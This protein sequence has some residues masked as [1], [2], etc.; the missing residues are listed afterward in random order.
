[1]TALFNTYK[2]MRQ[3][4]WP[5]RPVPAVQAYRAARAALENGANNLP[6]FRY[7]DVGH[8]VEW[9]QDGFRLVA[10]MEYDPCASADDLDYIGTLKTEGEVRWDEWDRAVKVRDA[11][12]WYGRRTAIGKLW[13][14]PA[15]YLVLAPGRSY[16][17]LM[18]YY[19]TK[20]KIGKAQADLEAR[21]CVNRD[22]ERVRRWL[23]DE[24]TFVIL[25]VTVYRNGVELASESCGGIES[26]AGADYFEGL[27]L[28]LAYQALHVAK[29]T[30]DDL[31]AGYCG[32][33]D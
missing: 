11:C 28:D 21:T 19:R 24:W 13:R 20:S 15:L 33:E 9:E 31:C 16:E 7:L 25:T 32:G 3:S 5:F 17:D 18:D 2:K 12:G 29:E 26:D 6:D 4:H 1:M 22:V 23:D 27:A 14:N 30:L 10:E 8:P